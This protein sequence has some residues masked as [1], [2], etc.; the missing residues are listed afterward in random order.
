VSDVRAALNR[1]LAK[2]DRVPDSD[3][4]TVTKADLRAVLGA[5]TELAQ[6]ESGRLPRAWQGDDDEPEDADAATDRDGDEWQR[7]GGGQWRLADG[8]DA[9]HGEYSLPWGELARFHGPLREVI[10]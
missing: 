8:L 10:R 3:S 1:I 5:L 9:Q 6:P 7:L 2:L 4:V